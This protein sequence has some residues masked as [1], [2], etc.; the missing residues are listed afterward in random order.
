MYMEEKLFK[1]M[2]FTLFNRITDALQAMEMQNY[3]QAENILHRAQ[4]E[5]EE[6]LIAQDGP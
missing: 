2:Y 6:Q 3:G 4:Q 5:A 1:K